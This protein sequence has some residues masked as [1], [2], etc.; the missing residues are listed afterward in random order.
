MIY[1]ST[2]NFKSLKGFEACKILNEI[3]LSFI[4]LSGGKH[5]GA[6]HSNLSSL[7]QCTFQIHNYFPPPDEAFVFNLATN[8]ESI[9]EQSVSL[10]QKGI[11]LASHLGSSYYSFHAGF[12][13][14]P[15]IRDLG[16]KISRCSL[17]N[18]KK[19]LNL[20]INRVNE[21]S[22]YAKR[23]NIKLLI[24]NNVFSHANKLSFGKNPF[25]M[26]DLKET[27]EIAEQTDQN[28]G[29]LIDVGHLKV[30]SN[31]QSFCKYEFIE[32]LAPHTFAYHLSENNGLEDSNQLFTN[33]S[34]FWPYIRKDLNYYT[35]EVYHPK[36]ELLR[37]QVNLTCSILNIS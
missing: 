23:N 3:G 25:L 6:Y 15:E 10:A 22:S 32:M 26:I 5:D 13:F 14:D 27:L 29:L 12:L 18:R 9:Y 2:G 37:D 4:E 34:W 20:F 30:S 35:I 11:K 8:N 7:N 36:T 17:I 31:I 24:E 28:V 21:L 16:K 19:A 33:D 1:T